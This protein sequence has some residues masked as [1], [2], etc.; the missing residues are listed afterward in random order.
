MLLHMRTTLNL[1]DEL[2]RAARV[3]AAQDG[4]TVTSVMEQALRAFLDEHAPEPKPYRVKPLKMGMPG[5]LMIDI[6]NNA[7]VREFLDAE[8]PQG[9][10][11][12]A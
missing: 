3:R 1:P 4:R 12:N 7:A 9:Y 10:H 8:D 2:Y 6:D 11:A 5:E